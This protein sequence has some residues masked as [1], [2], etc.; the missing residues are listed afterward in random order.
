MSPE[1]K[2]K[3]WFEAVVE[4]SALSA[5]LDTASAIVDECKMHLEPNGI[6]IRAVDPANVAMVDLELEESAFES[7]VASGGLIGVNLDRLTDVVRM[8]DSGQLVELE[9]DEETRKLHIHI[10]GMEYT[11]GL[12]DPDSIRQEPDIPE[13]DLGATVVLHGSDISR[14]V[15]AADMVSDHVALGV[16][17]DDPHFYVDADGDVD[18]VHLELVEDDV[19]DLQPGPADS[20]FSL[21]YLGDMNK[22]IPPDSEVAV[23]IGEQM[24]MKISYGRCD[25]HLDVAMM[26]APRISSD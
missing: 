10:D 2:Q 19:V 25:G 21:D 13:L 24:P 5:L 22:P 7:Y 26:I 16:E 6:A 18:D 20:L 23:R 8:A 12:I 11:L 14:A 15:T 17:S 1:S 9:L 4:E 3:E